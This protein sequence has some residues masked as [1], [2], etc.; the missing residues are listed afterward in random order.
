MDVLAA[1]GQQGAGGGSLALTAAA[2][3][4]AAGV[5]GGLPAGALLTAYNTARDPRI[6]RVA[7]AAAAAAA[8]A[9]SAAV[10]ATA[11]AA[12]AATQGATD[13]DAGEAATQ[14][15]SVH[16]IVL[17]LVIAALAG[18]LA[19]VV[20]CTCTTLPIGVLDGHA[21]GR[22]TAR[23]RRTSRHPDEGPEVRQPAFRAPG[24]VHTLELAE[25]LLQTGE[26]HAS[27]LTVALGLHTAP[28]AIRECLDHY[29]QARAGPRQVA[30]QQQ[31]T[32]V[33][34]Q[35]LRRLLG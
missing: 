22:R 3:L 35:P 11:D 7:S 2:A 29:R 33:R 30:L 27:V 10:Q 14:G 26:T 18:L 24:A 12:A 4:L 16:T 23:R 6:Q 17:L 25:H 5:A 15:Y 8:R 19:L 9:A 34:R 21:W 1:A 32:Q 31:P 20:C 28:A 13:P